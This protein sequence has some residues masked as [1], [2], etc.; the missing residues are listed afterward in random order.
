MPS[1]SRWHRQIGGGS[2][3]PS[4]RADE[5]LLSHLPLRFVPILQMPSCALTDD[6]ESLEPLVRIEDLPLARNTLNYRD[7]YVKK[8]QLPSYPPYAT[9]KSGATKSKILLAKGKRRKKCRGDEIN[10]SVPPNPVQLRKTRAT[11]EEWWQYALPLLKP[12]QAVRSVQAMGANQVLEGGDAIIIAPTAFG[13]TWLFYLP[14]L[15]QPTGISIV[16]TPLTALG[17]E[18]AKAYISIFLSS[19]EVGELTSVTPV[20]QQRRCPPSTLVAAIRIK[21]AWKRRHKA[22]IV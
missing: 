9:P 14:L 18:Q 2:S 10:P 3:S 6:S 22:I 5:A 15:A 4:C 13:K 19:K 7:S 20:H 12:G 21:I 8:A 16:V 1:A 11:D 17:V